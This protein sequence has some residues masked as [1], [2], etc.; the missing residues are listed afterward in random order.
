MQVLINQSRLLP[1]HHL[2]TINFYKRIHEVFDVNQPIT[3][4]GLMEAL[5]TTQ[6][7]NTGI[8]FYL[9][10]KHKGDNSAV[11]SWAERRIEQ[12]THL[13]HPYDHPLG[14][15][16]LEQMKNTRG[17]YPYYWLPSYYTLPASNKEAKVLLTKFIPDV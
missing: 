11:F 3:V 12:K 4:Y 5:D 17:T 10:V 1:S 7:R 14:A 8:S 9:A 15:K 6:D 2:N 13:W 16:T